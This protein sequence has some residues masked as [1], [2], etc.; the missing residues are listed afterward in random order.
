MNLLSQAGVEFLM[1]WGHFMAGITWIGLL[2]YF[3]FVQGAFFAEASAGTKNE[4]TVK[5]VPRALW[6]FRYAALLTWLTGVVI[7]LLY[8]ANYGGGSHAIYTTEKGTTILVGSLLGTIMMLNVW[9]II[10]RKQK[11]IIAST[12]SVL[13]GGEANP[14]AASAGRR[15]LLASRTNVVMSIPMLFSMA[16]ASHFAWAPSKTGGSLGLFWL[17]ILAIVAVLEY[18]AIAG[19]KGITTKF[20]DKHKD[21]IT[22]GFVVT[23]LIYAI[24]MF[25]THSPV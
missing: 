14:A 4:A 15:A 10:W 3:N 19:D 13:A 18:N 2:Y 23:A 22:A 21:A 17:L 8:P 25:T 5:L 24:A 9:G 1:R 20:L 7:L 16:G 6:W 11:V 12:A